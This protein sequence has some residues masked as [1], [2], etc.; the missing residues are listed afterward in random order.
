MERKETI[1]CKDA[2]PTRRV[3][4]FSS[5]LATAASALLQGGLPLIALTQNAKAADVDLVHDTMNGLLA[6]IV[7]GCRVRAFSM[8]LN[9]K[10][11]LF[12]LLL[13]VTGARAF[14]QSNP[15]D[16][17]WSGFI[18]CKLDVEQPGYS[19]HEIQTWT[20]TGQPPRNEGMWIH[21]ATWAYSGG[22]RIEKVQPPQTTNFQWNINVP[23]SDAT[24]AM[25]VRGTDKK[26]IIRLGYSPRP[27][28]NVASGTRQITLTGIPQRPSSFSFPV[29][30]W[31]WPW[32]EATPGTNVSG[33]MSI[34][35]ESLGADLTQPGG[36]PSA[37]CK[38]QFSGAGASP[39]LT[40]V[41][42]NCPQTDGI[43]RMFD[44]MKANAT[45][46]FAALIQQTQVPSK[47]AALNTQKQ[48]LLD[49]LE[50]LKQQNLKASAQTCR[51]TPDT[52]MAQNSSN[53][54][55][56][57]SPVAPQNSGQTITDPSQ[58][59]YTGTTN[60]SQSGN[61]GN[62]QARTSE[63]LSP[64]SPKKPRTDRN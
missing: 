3:F 48:K 50:N 29:T 11:P 53:S 58:P 12:L 56:G 34:Q 17:P 63:G 44:N 15:A 40:S 55:A 37:V 62:T 32:I 47:R 19:R 27:L 35:T 60:N 8:E 42:Q 26:F 38:Y 18:Q 5:L 57:L 39:D 52:N 10:R 45:R 64:T 25:F 7:P 2:A 36:P 49:D 1:T 13:L 24:L 23:P 51:G 16:G 31:S 61:S 6:F 28:Y 33:S 22:G 54:G 21:A 46:E 9:F 59:I 4:L 30:A 14:S 41:T 43:A 20:L